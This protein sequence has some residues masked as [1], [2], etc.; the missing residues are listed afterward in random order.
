MLTRK[1]GESEPSH[2][3][4]G[5]LKQCSCCWKQFWQ[6]HK[7]LNIELPYEPIIILVGTQ[8]GELR[9][10]VHI[11]TCIQRFIAALFTIAKKYVIA[12]YSAVAKWIKIWYVCTMEYYSPM[13]KDGV[14]TQS[15]G[16]LKTL[17]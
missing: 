17:C 10:C 16:T 7:T 12:K 13:K 15:G 8:P 6:F 14:L 5:N 4:D 3:A 1:N 9:T 2:T 11:K